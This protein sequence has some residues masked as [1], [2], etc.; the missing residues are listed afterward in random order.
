MD[1][2]V[3][4]M[5]ENVGPNVKQLRQKHHLSQVDLA[6]AIEV[7][8]DSISKIENGK[9]GTSFE[10]L[11]RIAR[12]FNVAPVDLL[13]SPEEKQLH[14]TVAILDRIDE[15]Q[16]KIERLIRLRWQMQDFS[17][18]QIDQLA[19]QLKEIFA[20]FQP[21]TPVDEDGNPETDENGRQVIRQARYRDLPVEDIR[22]VYKEIQAIKN[23]RNGENSDQKGG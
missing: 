12:F 9:R 11:D 2:E 8:V 6:E 21:Y 14:E 22:Q 4:L 16:E 13:G 18:R 7:T 1:S 20:F 15:Y 10:T 3:N 17:P 5:I 19:D 23:Y